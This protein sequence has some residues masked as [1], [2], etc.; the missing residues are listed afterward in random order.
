MGEDPICVVGLACR[1]PGG[2]HSPSELWDFIANKKSA[3]G[4][5]PSERFNIKGFQNAD[6]VE[7]G[8][9]MSAQG[10]YF[11]E[12]DVRRFDNNFFE[13]HNLETTYMDP[14]QRQLLEVVYECFENAGV[15]LKKIS[16]TSTG[17]Y[18]GNFT[19]DYQ[20]IQNKD[21]DYGSRYSATG[22]GTAIL[23]NRI[24]YIFNLHGPSCTSFTLDTACSSSLYCIHNAI[25][26][27]QSGDCDGAI[28]AGANLITSPEQH[29][30]TSLGGVLSPTSTCNTF[31]ESADGYGRAEGINA[32]YLK[33]LSSAL[34]DGDRISAV[35]RGTAVNA[36]GK[37]PGIVQPSPFLQEAV[38]RKAY[39]DAGLDFA[40]TDY[41]ECH[42]TGTAIGDPIEVDALASCFAGRQ[43][44]PLLI[45]SVKTNLGHSEAASGLTSLLKVILA[46]ENN[47]IPPTYGVK[48]LNPKLKL[49][50]RN[51]RVVTES[52]K[53]PCDI[54]R[55]SI[56]SFGYGGANAHL[57]VESRES[58]LNGSSCGVPY[59]KH[60]GNWP[61]VLPMS[62]KSKRSLELR[63]KD[64]SKSMRN[65]DPDTLMRLAFTLAQRRSHLEQ[66][67]YL[68]VL[69]ANDGTNEFAPTDASEIFPR[70][71]SSPVPIAFVFT[72]QGAQYAGM[73]KDL[74]AM[75]G[76][77]SGTIRQ[78]DTILQALP[79][80]Y[81]PDWTLEG[82]IL[83]TLDA[84][85]VHDVTRSQPLCTAI[86]IAI[87]DMLRSWGVHASKVIGHS[88][89]EIAAAYAAGILTAPQAII[90][91]YFR[92]YVVGRQRAKG[93]AMMAAGIG[94]KD[95]EK[96][97]TSND[98]QKEVCI[99]CVNSP[100]SVTLSGLPQGIEILAQELKAQGQF[101]RK[102]ETGGRAYHSYMMLEVGEMYE[103]LL[104]QHLSEFSGSDRGEV[105]MYSTVGHIGDVLEIF[106]ESTKSMRI[107][108]WREN[109]EKPVQFNAA[110]VTLI[111]SLD[112]HHL[113]EIGPHPALKGPIQQIRA[114][115][116]LDKAHLPYSA[117]LTRKQDANLCMRNL[118]G[119]LFT[120]GYEIDWNAVNGLPNSGM[121]PLHDL[122]TYPWDYSGGLLWHEP[123]ASEELRNREYVRHE[124]LGSKQL[125]GDGINWC[126]RNILRLSEMPWIRG[127]KVE[128]QI[129]F[130]AAGYMSVAIEAVSQMLGLVG[131][132]KDIT[133][134][135]H[136]V[137][138]AAALVLPDDSNVRGRGVE[139][140]TNV[141]RQKLSTTTVSSDWHEFSI[142]SWMVGNTT[143]HCAG[144]V[145]VKDYVGIP[146]SVTVSDIATFET[147]GSELWYEKSKEQGLCFEEQFRSLIDVRTDGNRK[148]LESICTTSLAPPATTNQYPGPNHYFVH[149]I[150]IDTCFQAPI[151]S[152]TGGKVKSLRAYLPVFVSQAHVRFL[153]GRD[154][155][156]VGSIHTRSIKTG[157]S[158]QK[159]DSSLRNS[160]NLPIIDMK[161]VRYSLYEGKNRDNSEPD[162]A[163]LSNLGRHPF[164]R[165][166]WK[167]DIFRL[168]LGSQE[169]VNDYTAEFVKQSP[170]LQM[171]SKEHFAT[172]GA[173][174]DLAGHKNPRLRVLEI[175]FGEGRPT[176]QRLS[177]LDKDKPFPRCRSWDLAVI[178]EKGELQ[179]DCVGPFLPVTTISGLDIG[180][181]ISNFT[182]DGVVVYFKSAKITAQLL[183][184]HF[185]VLDVEGQT[186]LATRSRIPMVEEN[187]N[188]YII[189][190]NPS[191]AGLRLATFLKTHLQY[192]NGV[193]HVSI[194][195][196]NNINTVEVSKSTICISMIEIE[197]E[198]LASMGQEEM[199]K[200]R[201]LTD[202]VT[203]LIW[204]IGANM[205]GVPNP[206]LAMVHGLSRAL[207][208][209]QPSLRFSVL[210]IGPTGTAL[211]DIKDTCQ[212][213]ASILF[214]SGDK[215]DKEF[216]QVNGL[217]HISRFVPDHQ[218]NSLFRRRLGTQTPP[219]QWKRDIS[220]IK[221]SPAR[222]SV[223]QVGITDSIHFQQICE[224]L[225]SPP[226]GYIDVD[227][228]AVSLNAK[229]VYL[230]SGHV[231]TRAGTTA[232]EL[233]GIVAVVPA[234]SDLEFE[235]GDR[236]VVSAPHFFTTRE[237]VPAWSVHKMLPSEEFSIMA[238]LPVVY[239]TALYAL[240]DRAHLRAGES[241]LIHAGAG[242]LGIAL[243][244]I[245]Q[246][247]GAVV[248]TTVGSQAKRDYLVQEL[249]IPES[250]IFS[251]RD[252]SFAEGIRNATGDRGM[253]VIVNS[254]VGD[255]M[256]TSWECIAQFGRFV[257]VGKREL[258]TVGR[259]NMGLFL[260]S[261]TFTAFDLSELFYHEDPYYRNIWASRTKQVLGLYRSGQIRPVPI[262]TF[263]VS[264]TV[265]A[266]R[267]FS[268]ADRIG[269]V[270]ISLENT[271]SLIP[272]A[273]AKYLTILDPD[274]MYLLVGCLGGLGRSLSRWML[275]RGA[276]KFC[277]LGRSGCDKPSAQMLVDS[278][279]IA[280]AT[281]TVVRGDV[282][283]MSDVTAAIAA[284]KGNSIG[285]VVQA[286]MGLQEALFSSMTSAAWQTA[287]QPKWTGTWNL[288]N[289][290]E[291]ETLD[292]FLSTSSMSGSVGT[293]TES[294]YCAANAFL[295]A[296]A[297]WRRA[298]GKPAI[299]IGLG[300][301]SEVGYLH[302]NPEVEALLLRRGIQPLNED[303]FLQVVDMSLSG[304][305]IEDDESDIYRE[306]HSSEESH[307]L[308]GLEPLRFRKLK[309]QGFDVSLEVGH[310]PRA[311][312]LSAAVAAELEAQDT[313]GH[314]HVANSYKLADNAPWLRDV[315]ASIVG[316]FVSEIE[317]S[318]LQDAVLRLTKKRFSNLILM[319][320]EQID[321]YKSLSLFG[322]DSMIAAEFRTW[323]WAT[324]KVDIPFLD[325]LSP[326]K[327]LNVLAGF[328]AS[329]LTSTGIPGN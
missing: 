179:M 110:M 29:L 223:A 262:T 288:H 269:K 85:R 192:Q 121:M 48:N 279:R 78:L 92:G 182:G 76:T 222:F 284:C 191:Q 115:I 202:T 233:S 88:S 310:D 221:A 278:L 123:R 79:L 326:Q 65:Y 245:A 193:N 59:L 32:I 137:H 142:S 327:N 51:F 263:D 77:F 108:Y 196:I 67:Q 239:S 316:A 101:A 70:E 148:R 318:S 54:R 151:I 139:L 15:S 303:E 47:S 44:Y 87:V 276:R 274:K 166:R 84:D 4:P 161:N 3:Q 9:S 36:N 122:P 207:M 149:P 58:Y 16:G 23:A 286:A 319:S 235:P 1:L 167:P 188:V 299:S 323:F 285:G 322:V 165:T 99:A 300:M 82:T 38:I 20:A 118:A 259:L 86:Q 281:V 253:D 194:I 46:F 312:I 291:G 42:G 307:I 298:Q 105:E 224:P 170:L 315:P 320:A 251:S 317:A 64:I 295:D 271:Q 181:L 75:E 8:G 164:L 273:P 113:I 96:L 220:L 66:K 83:G 185:T 10:G 5:L 290:L 304:M 296:F 258:V 141:S 26:A 89:G 37:T 152:V 283:S 49:K 130:P 52:E 205:S 104:A 267:Y 94:A 135:F 208:L 203:D 98:L 153:R 25:R 216:L 73:G 186:I 301:I 229:D 241:V 19:V 174:L 282:S 55:A 232:L 242:A 134:E 254:L 184:A 250:N 328:V 13:I 12:Q 39:S 114:G 162:S 111:S 248:Y 180:Q 175:A 109:L 325:L 240:E 72:G 197:H 43:G 6:G 215:D 18:V 154:D 41:V 33:R 214:S 17:V 171:R 14:Q 45:G 146:A 189:V 230:V 275:A 176:K 143:V 163:G 272:V 147:N 234:G 294:N 277:F 100:E 116:K 156:G 306:R 128:E 60:L 237:R 243:I 265:Q 69:K 261:A 120:H 270:V 297:R 289:A 200:L 160:T 231:E 183:A 247:I 213:V 133:F 209:E 246:I 309:S 204:I 287:I 268:S 124:L 40:G 31:D 93:G 225:T 210:D 74:L 119:N 195:D 212:N 198:F 159:I 257:E 95:A 21:P 22:S 324:F 157:F 2:I 206:D 187:R 255:L 308:T 321:G 103:E 218:L 107:R 292:F 63:I 211:P 102:L 61:L 34:R 172:V 199:N 117:T 136:D 313:A 145:R 138:F 266:Y 177:I 305:L 131:I 314:V 11:L 68:L 97:I 264:N 311:S 252:P 260:R 158:T 125:A 236:V 144:S 30:G 80:P 62:A 150:I 129:V 106:A 24:S 27:I 256:H 217:L 329:S 132:D 7:R 238:T 50:S 56:N 90:V 228:K 81:A 178:D 280:G 35:I 227:V 91:A 140:H 127:H 190:H 28:A 219:S 169:Y 71:S 249:G 173:L 244:N 293:A 126:W 112:K 53:W 226:P 302:E 155:L 57:I 168:H 201:I